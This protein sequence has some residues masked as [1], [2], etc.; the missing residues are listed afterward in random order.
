MDGAVVVGVP[1]GPETFVERHA[2][3]VVSEGEAERFARLLAR[4][5]DK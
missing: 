4:M 3:N 5:P 1:V 2:L